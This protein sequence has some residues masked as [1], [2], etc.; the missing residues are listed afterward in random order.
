MCNENNDN[1]PIKP[2]VSRWHC[3]TQVSLLKCLKLNRS[4]GLPICRCHEGNDDSARV[5]RWPCIK[6]SPPNDCLRLSR[7]PGL[8]ICRCHKGNDDRARIPRWPCTQLSLSIW[9]RLSRCPGLPFSFNFHD[10]CERSYLTSMFS[11]FDESLVAEPLPC[12]ALA[13]RQ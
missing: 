10:N 7:A 9:L 13:I 4:C 12:R 6:V 8:P 11:V 5:P 1:N 2:R 3:T